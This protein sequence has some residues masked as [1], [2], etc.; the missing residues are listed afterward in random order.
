MSEAWRTWRVKAGRGGGGGSGMRVMGGF[1]STVVP[2]LAERAS[3]RR[4]A[5]R[6]RGLLDERSMDAFRRLGRPW[7]R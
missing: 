1:E 6:E 2:Q 4:A 3:P 7:G 5:A